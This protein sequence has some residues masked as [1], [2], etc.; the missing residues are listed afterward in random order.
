LQRYGVV[1]LRLCILFQLVLLNDYQALSAEDMQLAL[2]ILLPLL[3]DQESFVY[4]NTLLVIRAL[5]NHQPGAVFTALLQ[6]FATADSAAPTVVSVVHPTLPQ[7][8]RAM[9]GEA[10]AQLLVRARAVKDTRPAHYQKVVQMLPPLVAVCLKL[11]RQRPTS[12]AVVAVQDS[13]DLNRMRIIATAPDS[14]SS[15]ELAT[16]DSA[17]LALR[18]QTS[19]ADIAIAAAAAD[20]DILRQS[21]VALLAEAVVTAGEGA[22]R[23]LDDVLDIAVGVLSMETEFTQSARAV[24]RYVSI[25]TCASFNIRWCGKKLRLH[26]WRMALIYLSFVIGAQG[27]GAPRCQRDHLLAERVHRRA[28]HHAGREDRTNIRHLPASLRDSAARRIARP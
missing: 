7:A 18:S 10:L 28:A 20:Q 26:Q 27:C 11:S 4:L 21:A 3:V 2:D 22:Y 25:A 15:S 13:V 24:R 1:S 19:E 8:R 6:S 9:V 16:T 5:A 17:T 12:A 23:Y 14:A